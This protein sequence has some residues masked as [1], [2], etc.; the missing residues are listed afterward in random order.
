MN[1]Q[2]IFLSNFLRSP[3]EIAAVAPSSRYV[4]DKV[5]SQIDFGK[6]RLIVEYGPGTGILT[7]AILERLKPNG[8]LVCFELNSKFCRHLAS[9]LDDPRLTIINDSAEKLDFYLD[10]LKIKAKIDYAL[11]SI[12]F[13]LIK[14]RR[15]HSIIRKT[16]DS[17]GKNGKF[18]VYQQYSWHIR[19]YLSFYFKKIST[20]FEIRNI[21]PTFIYRCEKAE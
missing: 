7:K 17:L 9:S 16:K 21:P 2:L 1:S 20:G 13:L 19:N 6:A 18:I 10:K 11:S 8:K 3:R 4:V 14:D 5:I 12:P 15:K